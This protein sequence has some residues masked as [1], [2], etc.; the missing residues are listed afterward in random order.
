MK[1]VHI[2]R[3]SI[4]GAGS[5]VLKDIPSYSIYVNKVEPIIRKRFTS[6]EIMEHERKLR[7][8]KK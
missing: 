6:E 3:G 4:I 7:E 1:G 2:G 5:I 8:R